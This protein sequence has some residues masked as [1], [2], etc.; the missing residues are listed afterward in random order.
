MELKI[1]KIDPGVML[2]LPPD[3]KGYNRRYDG[4]WLKEHMIPRSKLVYYKKGNSLEHGKSILGLEPFALVMTSG[5]VIKTFES[6]PNGE[7]K[8]RMLISRGIHS[9]SDGYDLL[10]AILLVGDIL[11]DYEFD[12]IEFTDDSTHD[13]HEKWGKI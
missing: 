3:W 9:Y 5:V 4:I 12:T 11:E 13:W 8:E 6:W 7:N 2:I 10:E 1:T